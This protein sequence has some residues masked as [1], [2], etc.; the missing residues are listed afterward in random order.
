M[1]PDYGRDTADIQE[2][3]A[4]FVSSKVSNYKR[5]RGGV[6]IIDALPRNPTGKLLKKKLKEFDVKAH[7][8]ES[9]L[10]SKL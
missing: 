8:V 7:H 9:K 1:K 3:I 5:L 2:E 4:T 10:A 6:V